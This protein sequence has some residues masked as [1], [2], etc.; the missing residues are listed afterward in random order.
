[1]NCLNFIMSLVITMPIASDVTSDQIGNVFTEDKSVIFHFNSDKDANMTIT[2]YNGKKVVNK[3]IFADKPDID[4]GQMPKSYYLMQ[5]EN[6]EEKKEVH[7]CVIPSIESRPKIDDS[8]IASDLATSWLVKPEQFDSLAQLAKLSGLFWIRD[9]ITWEEL[10]INRGKWADN[11]KYDLSADIQTKRGLKVYQVFHATPAWAQEVKNSHSFPDDLRDI[12]NFSAEMAKRY[13]GSVLAWEVWNEPDISVFSDELGDSYASMLKAMYL[14]FKSADPTLPVLIC[15]FAMGPGK[16]AETIFQNDVGNYFD[17]YN[18]HIYDKVEKHKERALA[19]INLMKKYGIKNKPIWLT[20]AGHP[21]RRKDE[22]VEYTTEQGRDV[23]EFLPKAII[24]SLSAGVDKYFWFILPYYRENDFNLFG[25]LRQDLTPTAGYC[26]ISA[27]TYA[28]GKAKYL[29][30]LDIEGVNAHV[31]ERDDNDITIALWVDEGKK[32]PRININ[33][34]KAKI[35]D[36]MGV[37]DEVVINEGI[38]KI[39]ITESIKYLVIPAGSLKDNPVIDYPREKFEVEQYNPD[40]ISPI[41]VRLKFQIDSRD[42]QAENYRF[43]KL[44]EARIGIELYNF[45]QKEFVCR[46][47]PIIPDGWTGS[48]NDDSAII[49]RMGMTMRDIRLMPSNDAKSE[50]VEFRVNVIDESGNIETFTLAWIR[51]FE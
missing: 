51:A 14:G 48:I 35:I 37:D 11:T 13:K 6:E 8:A 15:S 17:I 38:S 26:S 47:E 50:S 4:L 23:A 12:Y 44:E 28:L 42:K 9:R 34:E 30:R 18:Y 5:I 3:K 33:A 39:T 19:H 10:E 25:L 43:K 31:F 16:F 46:I 1:M 20:E 21:I 24:T 49:G 29:G 22:L 40:K 36:V 45:S 32:I 27:C 41:V 7:F 2:D